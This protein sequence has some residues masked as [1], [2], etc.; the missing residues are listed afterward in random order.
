MALSMKLRKSIA[1]NHGVAVR[2]LAHAISNPVALSTIH[3]TLKRLNITF[4]KSRSNR[5]NNNAKVY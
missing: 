1:A 4:E 2:K 5:L 3:R